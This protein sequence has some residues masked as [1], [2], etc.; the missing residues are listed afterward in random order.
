MKNRL[1]LLMLLP[2]TGFCQQPFSIN[3][4]IDKLKK[5][6]KIYLFYEAGGKLLGDSALVSSTSIFKFNGTIDAATEAHLFLN[7]NP[8]I[9]QPKKGEKLDRVSFY[10]EPGAIKLAGR[11]SLSMAVISGGPMNEGNEKLKVMLK[12]ALDKE[13][14]FRESLAN[15]PAGQPNSTKRLNEILKEQDV[16]KL[17][18]AEKNLQSPFSLYLLNALTNDPSSYEEARK[19]FQ[20]LS[21]VLKATPSGKSMAQRFEAWD[22]TTIGSMA[23]D[24]EQKDVNGNAV[25]LSDFKGKY[26]LVDFWASWC[27]P[28]R[29]ESP[30]LVEANSK[31]KSKGLN[32]I[33]V[34]C[35]KDK[36][37]WL[38]AVADDKLDWTQLCDLTG[39]NPVVRKYGVTGIPTNFLIDP[40]GKIIA[41]GL[42]GANL[43]KKLEEVFG[44]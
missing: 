32:I 8:L 26:V 9:N 23:M 31:Y 1:L 15:L 10:I 14:S 42:R 40:S 6:D 28:C 19:T 2:L 18:F 12:P 30:F 13:N 29:W 20:K 25:K 3:G 34:S 39:D 5:G 36:T 44:K 37:A 21:P 41:V 16:I 33:G 27:G 38:K 35:D 7:K 17:S 22:K 24:F 4:K 43:G 11:N